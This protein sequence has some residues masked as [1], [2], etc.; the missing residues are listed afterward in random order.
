MVVQVELADLNNHA[1]NV[2]YKPYMK[3][4]GLECSWTIHS[5]RINALCLMEANN[6]RVIANED[7]Y[8]Y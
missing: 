5:K 1:M 8:L 7:M 6:V 2:L 3:D 4:S